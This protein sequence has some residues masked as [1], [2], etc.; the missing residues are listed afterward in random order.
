MSYRKSF[1]SL[2]S[3]TNGAMASKKSP[4]RSKGIGLGKA[5]AVLAA[6]GAAAAAGY[7]FYASSRAK[8]HR[9]IVA[10]WAVN[11]KKDVLKKAEQVK[12]LDA[13]SL[14]KIVD[15]A[16]KAYENVRSINRND[17]VRAAEELKSNWHAIVSELSPGER[18]GGRTGA[19]KARKG[20]KKAAKKSSEGS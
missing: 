20:R 6:A 1:A 14:A 16:A 13:Q 3:I 5:A 4:Q 9:K 15:E 11:L 10:R 17:V 2:L 7:Y 18:R 8:D 19:R 12:H